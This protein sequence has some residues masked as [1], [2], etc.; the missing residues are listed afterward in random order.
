[1]PFV[2]PSSVDCSSKEADKTKMLED[3]KIAA[4]YDADLE[5]FIVDSL[6]SEDADN[7]DTT[8]QQ[9]RSVIMKQFF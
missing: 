1:M 6:F 5:G 3:T 2:L 9:M 4:C 7:V 8:V